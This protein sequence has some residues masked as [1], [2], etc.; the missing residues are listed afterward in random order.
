MGPLDIPSL[1]QLRAFEAAARLESV[2]GAAREVNLSQPAL[3][4]SIHALEAR[5]KTRLFDRRRSGC[6]LTELGAILLPRVRRF[7]D[8]IGAALSEPVIGAPFVSRQTVA[9]TINKISGLQIRNL[10]AISESPSFEAAARRLDISQP[11]LYRPAKELERELRR[12]LYQRT[13]RGVTTTAQ[14]AELA[15]RF[16][17]ALREIEYGLEELQAAQGLVVSRIAI[18]N[19]PHS[20]TQILT[21]AINRLLASYPTARIQ[22][23]DGP[24]D[25]LL[26]DLRAGKLDLLFGVLRKPQWAIDVKEELL[27]ENPY[28][29]VARTGHPLSRLSRLTLRDL[30]R[31]DWIM[32]APGTP[33]RQAFER[34]F[35]GLP[36]LPKVNIE[37]TSLPIYRSILTA[38]DQ[39]TLMSRLATQSDEN[40]GLTV[41]SVRSPHLSRSDGV[42]SRTDW[43]PPNVHLQFLELLRTEA[44]RL[45]RGGRSGSNPARSGSRQPRFERAARLNQFVDL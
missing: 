35:A 41:L 36:S 2:S 5:L 18:G 17:V 32:P 15:R 28:V 29:V 30:A 7:F 13:A 22:L 8:H 25:V 24:Y 14:G 9:A 39:L 6:Y 4:Q 33:R 37:T 12:T 16:Q 31:Y 40:A 44:R 3:T 45:A 26:N 43:H 21:A 27:F 19:I 11:S 20:D 1:R 10:I 38:T 34:M 42:A 23:V